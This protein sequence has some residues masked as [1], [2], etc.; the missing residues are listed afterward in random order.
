MLSSQ[1]DWLEDSVQ[2][3]RKGSGTIDMNKE[4]IT[5]RVEDEPIGGTLLLSDGI[6]AFG[7]D[8]AAFLRTYPTGM[9]YSFS[10]ASSEKEAAI[11]TAIAE[12]YADLK[13]EAV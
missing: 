12:A 8:D 1:M 9:T 4:R 10:N 6:W 7:S 2:P 3:R 11:K 5:I 13:T